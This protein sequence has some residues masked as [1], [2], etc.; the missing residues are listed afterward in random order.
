MSIGWGSFQTRARGRIWRD[1]CLKEGVGE[2]YLCAAKT[3]DTGDPALYGFD[4]IVEFPPHGVRV[5]KKNDLYQINNPAFRG[6][7]MITASW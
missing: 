3:Y 2:L 7:I 6:S 5:A 4:A 1:I